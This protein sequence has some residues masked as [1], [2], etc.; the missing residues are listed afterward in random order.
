MASG[1]IMIASNW[2]MVI[3]TVIC[4]AHETKMCMV[5]CR[6]HIT[7]ALHDRQGVSTVLILCVAD[8]AG[9]QVMVGLIPEVQ[10]SLTIIKDCTEI[11]CW[12]GFLEGR[13]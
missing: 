3:T 5:Q 7:L 6:Y 4:A 13:D 1:D 9:M 10:I 8:L 11:K 12:T 2:L